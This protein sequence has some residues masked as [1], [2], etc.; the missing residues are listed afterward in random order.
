MGGDLE[1]PRGYGIK[2]GVN[3]VGGTGCVAREP[4][5]FAMRGDWRSRFCFLFQG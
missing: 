3:R 4:F 5:A 2:V 1:C